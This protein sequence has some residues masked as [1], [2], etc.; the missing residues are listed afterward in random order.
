MKTQR[1]INEYKANLIVDGTPNTVFVRGFDVNHGKKA[2]AQYAQK[3]FQGV[4]SLLVDSFTPNR[5]VNL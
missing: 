3:N 4:S 1:F 2:L 5:V